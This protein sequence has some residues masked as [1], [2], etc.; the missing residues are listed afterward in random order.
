MLSFGST[1]AVSRN[2]LFEKVRVVRAR[3]CAE[4]VAGVWRAS[5]HAQY[6][7][8]LCVL[9]SLPSAISHSA[10]CAVATDCVVLLT[11]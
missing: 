5:Q 8:T 2:S 4:I 11:L 10:E 9:A 1:F 6:L 3:R 7:S